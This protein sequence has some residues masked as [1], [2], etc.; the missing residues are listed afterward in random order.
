MLES[1]ILFP[2][3]DS[4]EHDIVQ[5]LIVPLLSNS[6]EYI[7]GVGFFTSGWLT[8]ASRGLIELI[9]KGGKA[10]FVV[11]PV[12][13]EED[14]EALKL[15][16]LAKRSEIVKLRVRQQIADLAIALKEDVLLALTWMVCDHLLKFNFAVSRDKNSAGD[17]HDKVGVFVDQSGA[18]VAIHGSFN[19]TLKG[20]LNYEAFSVFRSWVPGERAHVEWHERRLRKLLENKNDQMEVFS[21][22]QAV[23]E[24]FVQVRPRGGR[25][26]AAPLAETGTLADTTHDPFQLRGYQQLAIGRWFES[27]CLGIL[28]MATGTGKTVT[29]LGVA[30][31]CLRKNGKLLLIILV[32]YL[33]LL[34]QWKK[35]SQ[36]FGFMPIIC[37][38]YHPNW[39]RE[40]KSA[41]QDL[42]IGTRSD[43]CLIMT[44]ETGAIAKLDRFVPEPLSGF[45]L[46]IGD[47]VHS[48]GAEKR[49]SAL[50]N[51]AEMRL[52]LSATPMRWYDSTGT[53][54]IYDYF[55]QTCFQMPLEEAIA[56]GFLTP[57]L[58]FPIIIHLSQSE[59]E[60]YEEI[61]AKIAKL[62]KHIDDVAASDIFSNF[63][64]KRASILA[65]AEQKLPRL[66]NLLRQKKDE[67]ET[68]GEP[69]KHAL[70]YCA[71]GTHLEILLEIAG[72]GFRCR[73]FVHTVKMS[74]RK[75][76][77]D[78]FSAGDIQALVSVKCL[79]EGV[80]VPATKLAFILA[81]TG[82]PREF[83]QR[84][85]RVLRNAP[86]KIRAEIYDFL[87][88][89]NP[90]ILERN[91]PTAKSLLR[92]EMAR[93][94]EFAFGA[95]N[96][97]AAR[98]EVKPMLDHYGMLHLL[99]IRPWQ[100]YE[101]EM[102]ED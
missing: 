57:Y 50:V 81:S 101:K 3:Y 97:F 93:F 99:D 39:R 28:E 96:Q 100:L 54:R 45:T 69:L 86:G 79:D 88:F 49:Q 34:E 25:P 1:L 58:Y 14:W 62:R 24:M 44:H 47:E 38:G 91:H 43:V 18:R 66:K 46:L 75:I 61:S 17:Y 10:Q 29:A 74:D 42:S 85:G 22:S 55:G 31:E 60:D 21:I 8:L 77:L 32:P 41:I 53:S 92:R 56:Q 26:Y 5:E 65:S 70:I 20:S 51:V 9:R 89:P 33:H 84:R 37:S 67:A 48:L 64:I 36:A 82:N 87:V 98:N 95:I 68:R 80:D 23:R 4:S 73:E 13:E 19:D 63:L 76:I 78:E 12:M 52:G 71:P 11:S 6:T 16:D 27:G 30:L 7:R 15:G 90:N 40:A 72:M 2:V 102:M 83:V 35:V 59:L 94:A